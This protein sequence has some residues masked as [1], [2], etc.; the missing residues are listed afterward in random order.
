MGKEAVVKKAKK[1]ADNGKKHWKAQ[2]IKEIKY[3][4]ETNLKFYVKNYSKKKLFWK[5]WF[6]KFFDA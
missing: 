4:R 3:A 6:W 5:F 1:K 2:K